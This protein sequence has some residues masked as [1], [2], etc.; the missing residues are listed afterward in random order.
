MM[1]ILSIF[2]LQRVLLCLAGL[3]KAL[4]LLGILEV[5]RLVLL[6]GLL[7]ACVERRIYVDNGRLPYAVSGSRLHSEVK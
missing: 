7:V 2:Y 4:G 3:M 1:N 5:E 6:S